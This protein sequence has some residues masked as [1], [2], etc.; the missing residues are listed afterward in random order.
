MEKFN[1]SLEQFL[2]VIKTKFPEQKNKIDEYYKF[3][4]ILYFLLY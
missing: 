3:E 4:N 1:K 2:N